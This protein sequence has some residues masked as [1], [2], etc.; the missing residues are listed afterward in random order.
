MTIQAKGIALEGAE[1]RWGVYYY[2]GWLAVWVLNPGFELS[3]IN[4]GNV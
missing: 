4:T 3:G 1:L 2:F